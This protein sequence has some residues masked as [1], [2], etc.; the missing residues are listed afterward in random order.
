MNKVTIIILTILTLGFGQT[1]GQ[2]DK[3]GNPVF[4][5]VSTTEKSFDDFLLI[6]NYYTLKNNIENKQSSVFVSDNPTLDQVEKA[7]VNLPSDFFILTKE[8]KMVVLVMLQNDPKRQFMTI[9]MR[10]NQQSTFTCNL[11]GDITENR[12]NEIIKEK[13]DTTATIDNGNLKFNGKEFKIISSQEIEQAV[14]VLIKKEKLDKKKPSDVMVPSKNEINSFVLNETKEGGKLDFFTE[15]KGKEYDGVQIKAG[16]FT[17]KQ[18]V[19]LYK[20][21]RACFDIGINTVEDAYE[22]FAEHKGKPVNERDKEYIKAGF[23]KKW[24][25]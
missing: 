24:E 20:W 9:E 8:S 15:I 17:T 23:Y 16:V 25:K 2:T 6:S 18:S 21:G 11:I 5:S 12:A 13:Y 3:N 22:I 7:A 10:T 1:F 14:S 19:A 4:N